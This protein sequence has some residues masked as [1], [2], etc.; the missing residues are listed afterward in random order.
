[1]SDRDVLIRALEASGNDQGAALA[2]AILPADAAPP[3]AGVPA[4]ATD[5]AGRMAAAAGTPEGRVELAAAATGGRQT[6][7]A[8]YEAMGPEQLADLPADEFLTALRLLKDG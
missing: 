5:V 6:E 3:T 1:M 4:P 2:R 7:R 8:R